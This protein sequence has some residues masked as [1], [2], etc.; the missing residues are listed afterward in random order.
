MSERCN[1]FIDDAL[2]FVRRGWS[3]IPTAGKRPS[4]PWKA[5]QRRTAGEPE[6][7]RMFSRKNVTGMAVILGSASGGLVCRDYDVA[8]SYHR[9]ASDNPDLAS[10]LPTVRTSRGY[11]V[12]F[13][14]PD[15]YA[16]LGDGEYRG[17]ASHYC[18][19]P[20]SSHPDGH[21]YTW[22]NPLPAGALPV[23][24]DP[25]RAGLLV[26]AQFPQDIVANAF[27]RSGGEIQ[28]PLHCMCIYENS[29]IAIADA[30]AGTLPSAIGQR[31]RRLFD[32]AQRLKKIMPN[33]GNDE[34]EPVVQQWFAV[35]LPVIGTKEW[36]ETWA[37]FTTAWGNV[38]HVV[39]GRW[40][41]IVQDS[42]LI[43]ID[44][45]DYDGAAAAIIRLAAALQAHHGDGVGW[46]LSCRKAGKVAKVNHVRAAVVLKDLVSVGVIELVTPGGK[47]PRSKRA[48]EYRFVGV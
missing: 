30:I 31:N 28:Y 10:A 27:A 18:L 45:G 29:P 20:P 4:S 41:E 33:A 5:F 21:T 8:D 6:L 35:A 7:H 34:L 26:P 47:G 19:L 23:I 37:D 14:G 44:V 42:C 17:S 36:D 40:N 13:R 43:D 1:P 38:S 2:M 12:Y 46:P 9:W 48:A 16:D 3:I 15:R 32:L 39:G 25:V 11:H 22:V 24:D